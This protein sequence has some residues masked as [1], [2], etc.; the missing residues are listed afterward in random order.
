MHYFTCALNF[1]PLLRTIAAPQS[2]YYKHMTHVKYSTH[3]NDGHPLC[4]SA[5]DFKQII[6]SAEGCG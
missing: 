2:V 3:L 5:V 4:I 6:F 1:N